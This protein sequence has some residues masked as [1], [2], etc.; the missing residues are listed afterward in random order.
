MLEEKIEAFAK[1]TLAGVVAA[2]FAGSA[3]MFVADLERGDT[4]P[5]PLMAQPDYEALYR[6]LLSPVEELLGPAPISRRPRM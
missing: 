3:L 2:I 4:R 5:W 1:V 6:A